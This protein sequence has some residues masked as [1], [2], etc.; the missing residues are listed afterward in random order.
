MKTCS[1]VKAKH[2]EVSGAKELRK[3]RGFIVAGDEKVADIISGRDGT[4]ICDA[5]AKLN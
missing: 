1:A 2:Y 4:R 3:A 5:L